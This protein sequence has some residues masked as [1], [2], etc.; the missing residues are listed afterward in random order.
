MVNEEKHSFVA[1]EA[2]FHPQVRKTRVLPKEFLLYLW[3][4]VEVWG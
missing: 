1:Y 2:L 4:G 3:V